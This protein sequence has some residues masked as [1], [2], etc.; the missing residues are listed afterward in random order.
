MS[1][2]RSCRPRAGG[3]PEPRPT[4]TSGRRGC[5]SGNATPQLGLIDEGSFDK[6]RAEANKAVALLSG[7]YANGRVPSAEELAAARSATE[8]APLASSRPVQ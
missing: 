8:I 4:A 6:L 5:A 3:S 2:P 1:F 7:L